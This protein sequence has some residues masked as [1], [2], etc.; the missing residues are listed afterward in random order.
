[1][2]SFVFEDMRKLDDLEIQSVLR[3][4]DAATLVLALTTASDELMNR[5]LA[6]MGNRA[7]MLVGEDVASLGSPPA[8][9]VEKAQ[10]TILSV[11]RA[12]VSGGPTDH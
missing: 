12:L 4:V 11:Y 9:D 3:D 1:M 5:I 6:N 7:A 10:Q 8:G 2:N